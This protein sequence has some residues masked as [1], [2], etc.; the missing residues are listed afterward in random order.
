M[1]CGFTSLQMWML[2]K[3]NMPFLVEP[4][5]SL[6]GM[7]LTKK[8]SSPH[9]QRNYWKD[10]WLQQI[11]EKLRDYAHFQMVQ[12][13]VLFMENLPYCHAHCMFSCLY[14]MDTA[15]RIIIYAHQYVHIFPHQLFTHFLI[16]H[17]LP[18]NGQQFHLPDA[19][20]NDVKY[21]CV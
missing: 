7:H 15:I 12:V 17:G 1:V 3:C 8:G 6:K 11:L 14:L 21:A 20:I 2:R 4:A 5:I 18:E 9:C 10:Y 19:T 13:Q 16:F